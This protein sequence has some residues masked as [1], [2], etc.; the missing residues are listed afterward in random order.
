VTE[1]GDSYV[2]DTIGHRGHLSYVFLWPG[3]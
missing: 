1:N 3:F 2:L